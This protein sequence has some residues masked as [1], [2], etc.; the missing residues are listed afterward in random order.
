MIPRRLLLLIAAGIAILTLVV[1][2]ERQLAH[3]RRTAPPVHVAPRQLAPRFQV[4]D[5]HR[6][7]VKFE[8]FLGRQRVLLLFFDAELGAD[9]DPYVQALVKNF[10]AIQKAGV[11]V[12][13]I[14]DATPYA[15]LEAEKKLGREFPFPLLTD[16]DLK[17]PATSPVHR[18]Y[19][20]YDVKKEKSRNGM[21][22]IARD[23]T[24]PIGPDGKPLPVEDADEA[25]RQI[26]AGDWPR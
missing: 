6:H 17:I 10:D 13:A 7:V 18:L 2:R 24:L 4:A 3:W 25:I 16:I 19:G 20:L 1:F 8:R 26:S 15:N 12:I 11:E 5:H 23:G 21:F 9:Q 14:S 22:L